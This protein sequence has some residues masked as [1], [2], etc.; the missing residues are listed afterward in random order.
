M[1]DLKGFRENTLKMTQTE[2][3]TLLD[4]R[5]DY[6]SRLEQSTEQTPL[7]IL[8]KIA[9]VTGTTIDELV[10]FKRLDPE[11]LTVN[12]TWRTAEFTK[13]NIVD[14]LEMRGADYRRRWGD[15]YNIKMAELRKKIDHIISKPRLAIVGHSDVGK[16]RLINSLLGTEKMP[17]SWTPT[18]AINVYIKHIQDRPSYM[19]EEAW[20]FRAAPEFSNIAP[21]DER[22]LHDEKYCRGWKLTGGSAE[23]LKKYGTRQ[24]EEYGSQ[25]AGAAVIFVDSDFLRNCDIVDL[26]GFGTGDRVEDD[27][28]AFEGKKNA[29]I[30]IYMSIANGFMREGDIDYLKESLMSLQP[31]EQAATNEISPLANLFVI[32]S[33]AHTVDRGNPDSLSSILDKGCERF[34]QSLPEKVLEIREK[35]TG[36]HYDEA[37]IRSRF[38]TYTTDIPMLRKAFENDLRA[39]IEHIPNV[40]NEK[41]KAYIRT[42]IENYDQEVDQ[43]I[44]E[45]EEILEHREGYERMLSEIDAKEPERV[46]DNQNR[47]QEVLK[48]INTLNASSIHTFTDKYGAL[49]SADS[50][51]SIIK[52]KGLK[53][54]K[55]DIQ[56]LI[57]YLGSTLQSQM[58]GILAGESEKLT[59]EI[60]D[61][62]E[63]FQNEVRK[64]RLKARLDDINFN[65]D[66]TKSFA[67]GLVGLT[68]LSGLAVWATSLGHLGTYILVAQGVSLL[69]ALGISVGGT[70]VGGATAISMFG[71][72]VAIG[73]TIAVLTALS[74]YSLVNGGWDKSLAKKIVNEYD[75]KKALLKYKD[76]IEKYWDDTAEAFNQAADS[77]DD[78]WTAYLAQLQEIVESAD[79]GD[80]ERKIQAHKEYKLFLNE[81]PL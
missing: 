38:F 65:F 9:N 20:I 14:Y 21:W 79:I 13:R 1:F 35:T 59:I 27:V 4:V 36:H 56:I 48:V 39:L 29:D 44:H 68:N 16:S 37:V 32:A 23:I 11:P 62:L 5:Q 80:I 6:I 40:I 77:L 8:I 15:T 2:F 53:K 69:S 3:A 34:L 28:M 31:V 41:A 64:R 24:G 74:V 52:S 63:H 30:L 55:E 47:R 19:E 73:I 12:N 54:K 81:I 71:G 78:E 42:Q 17:T 49:I 72:P 60:N 66:A 33:Q 10:N 75:A 57:S 76:V 18:T 58:Q 7:Q 51:V 67:A 50:I 25:E 46:N 70:F 45:F 26:P 22:R 43:R 61:Y